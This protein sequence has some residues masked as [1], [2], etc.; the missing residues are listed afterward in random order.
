MWW[1]YLLLG[2]VVGL[3]VGVLGVVLWYQKGFSKT[4]ES[5][6]EQDK[7]SVQEAERRLSEALKT[8][9]RRKQEL[10]LEAK[11][12][13]QR[14]KS[15][16][17]QSVQSR[18]QE[19]N[20]EKNRLEQKEEQL[21]RKQ[22]S[23][24][25]QLVN[26]AQRQD[27]VNQKL[28]EAEALHSEHQSALERVAGLSM[29]EAKKQVLDQAEMTFR[30]EQAQMLRQIED[31]TRVKSDQIAR[32]IVI[33]SIQ[34]YASEYVAESTVSVVN[35]PS[36]EMKGRIIGREGRN[37]RA[38][39]TITGVDLIIDDTP[40]AVILS[41]FD[42]IRRETA[43]IAL[44]K[45]VQ[46]GR[47]H[48]S[49][50]EEVV[51]KSRKELSTTI[52]KEGERAALETGV[53]GLDS[54]VILLLGRL[55]YRT[56]YGQNVLQHAIEV[57]KITGLLAAELGLDVQLA[58]RA[59]LLHD[60]GKSADFELEGSH[61]ELGMDLAEKYKEPDVVVNA[62]G[63]HH[64]DVDPSH[65]ISVLVAASD[66]ISAARPGA[67]RENLE[68]YI[69]RLRRLE[70]IAMSH[71]GVLKSYAIQAGREI[72]VI[73]EPSKLADNELELTARE[74]SRA[75]ESELSYPGQ[76]KISMI[77]ETRATAYAK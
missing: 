36:E 65:P 68:T 74:I 22:Q 40:E 18:R 20:K 17:E 29:E 32:D 55:K 31:E 60:L 54:Q 52:R 24:D 7:E 62:I 69:K 39:E 63:S 45:L 43:R 67:R 30:H 50:I 14:S 4:R 16:F 26:V 46:D 34:R 11:E 12:E 8:G 21:D 9:E 48:P 27:E 33:T 56:S 19:L 64:G 42:P 58:K 59:G 25:D 5:L 57:S 71:E 3:A 6:I 66:A 23:L 53:I 77:R 28:E 47:I 76:I 44:E 73:V 2:L 13:I 72:R 35:L 70:E 10:L 41:C 38:F 49:R 75:I 1:I 15:T 37:I 61:V 51:D